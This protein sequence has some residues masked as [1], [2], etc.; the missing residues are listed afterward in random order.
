LAWAC[1][2]PSS[3]VTFHN[4]ATFKS[5]AKGLGVQPSNS[6][7]RMHKAPSTVSSIIETETQGHKERKGQSESK[8]EGESETETERG[9][10]ER[11]RENEST[12][13]S[14]AFVF[15]AGPPL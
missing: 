3:R 11:E 10:R 6:V 14:V 15:R 4:N 1:Q 2:V 5:R 9:E 13:R 12:S 8:R 7:I